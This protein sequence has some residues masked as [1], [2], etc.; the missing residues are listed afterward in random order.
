M[1]GVAARA[2][3]SPPLPVAPR[4]RTISAAHP[5]PTWE[6]FLYAVIVVNFVLRNATAPNNAADEAALAQSIDEAITGL[7][8]SLHAAIGVR[9]ATNRQDGALKLDDVVQVRAAARRCKG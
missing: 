4:R 3:Y 6:V 9:T 7:A 5:A 8:E 2:H 1:S